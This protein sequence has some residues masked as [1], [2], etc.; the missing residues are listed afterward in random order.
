MEVLEAYL[1]GKLDDKAMYEVEK[2]SLEDPFLADALAGLQATKKRSHNLSVLQQRLQERMAQKPAKRKSWQLTSHRLSIATTAAVLFIVA[3]LFFIMRQ[4]R[5]P[6]DNL[7]KKVEVKVAPKPA[8]NP[9]T[10]ATNSKMATKATINERHQSNAQLQNTKTAK[11]PVKISAKASIAVSNNNNEL[12]DALSQA[13][14]NE[15]IDIQMPNPLISEKDSHSKKAKNMGETSAI[16]EASLQVGNDKNPSAKANIINKAESKGKLAH[17]NI[18]TAPLIGWEAFETYL[19]TNNRFIDDAPT[20]K[21]VE[22]TAVIKR[23]GNPSRIRV[24]KSLGKNLD[25]EAIR[26]LK[27]G[28]KWSY[29]SRGTNTAKITVLF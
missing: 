29:D 24:V 2:L 21:T 25:T 10:L 17:G 26:L 6:V 5:K 22:L 23:N 11:P 18:H 14:L 28:G 3:S 20:G 9:A 15:A 19:L 8:P 13:W 7:P 16:A 12:N 4:N 1:D 27:N